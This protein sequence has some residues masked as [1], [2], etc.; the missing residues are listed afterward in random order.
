MGVVFILGSEKVS[1]VSSIMLK[2][3]ALNTISGS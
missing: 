3:V 1:I 2:V